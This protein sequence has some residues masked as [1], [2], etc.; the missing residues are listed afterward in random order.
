[1]SKLHPTVTKQCSQC[2]RPSF[3]RGWC[4]KHYRRAMSTRP[5]LATVDMTYEERFDYYHTKGEGCWEWHG[6]TFGNRGYGAYYDG[7]RT[8]GAH[9]HAYER[10]HGP[11]PRGMFICHRCDN[12]RCVRPDH[13]FAGSPR[14]NT[15]DMI[16]KGRA[17]PPRGTRQHQCK[18]N[19]D[20]VRKIRAMAGAINIT[21][22]ARTYG[23]TRAT[24]QAVI[25]RKNWAHVADLT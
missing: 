3:C 21:H 25:K 8:M 16:E 11:I 2:E 14:D 22:T 18:L 6:A 15:R 20:A 12:P 1:M 17:N 24:I 4:A 10:V 9:R 13:L 19:E 23:V 7:K 5:P